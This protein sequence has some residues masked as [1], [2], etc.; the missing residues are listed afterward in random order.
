MKLQE[1]YKIPFT[2]EVCAQTSF[3]AG[4]ECEIEAVRDWDIVHCNKYFQITTD[5]SLRNRHQ[6]NGL[7]HEFISIP[8]KRDELVNAFT[9]LQAGLKFHKDEDPFSSRTSTHVHINCL[10]LELEQ[11]KTI[12][13]LY[14]LFEEFFFSL[15]KPDRRDNIHCVP[16]TET[17]MAIHYSRPLPYMIQYWHKYTAINLKRLQDLGTLEFRHLHGTGDEKEFDVWLKVLENLWTLGQVVT[18]N[19]LTLKDNGTIMRW[20]E[21]IFAPSHNILMLKPSMFDIARNSLIDVKFAV[22]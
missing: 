3:V 7:G 5:G 2:S 21:T 11:I 12:V 13:L 9:K 17:S 15:V 14:A 18:I 1:K 22:S 16:L 4:V 10:N 20:F 19:K 6:P 8:L